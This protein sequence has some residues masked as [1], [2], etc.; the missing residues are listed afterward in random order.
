MPNLF[1][2]RDAE[3]E[4]L[5]ERIRILE[6]ELKVIVARYEDVSERYDTLLD[7]LVKRHFIPNDPKLPPPLPESMKIHTK[8]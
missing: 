2:D 3:T 7:M 1:G 5:K 6:E 4:K 8:R